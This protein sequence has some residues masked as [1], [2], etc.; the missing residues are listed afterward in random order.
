MDTSAG[1]ATGAGS[2]GAPG[3]PFWALAKQFQPLLGMLAG[4]VVVGGAITAAGMRNDIVAAELRKEMAG[5]ESS[6]SEK[7]AGLESSLSQ[8]VRGLESKLGEKAAGL[9]SKLG[10]QVRGL[11]GKLGEKAAG[12][13]SML[14]AKLAGVMAGAADKAEAATLRVLKDYRIAAAGGVA[15]N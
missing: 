7:A 9:E 2:A 8:Q 5:L 4:A 6:L 15:G 1:A 10:E 14:D 13:E 3:D 11:E 12:L